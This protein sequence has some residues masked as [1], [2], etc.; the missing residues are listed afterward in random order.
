MRRRETGLI[1]NNMDKIKTSPLALHELV[2]LYLSGTLLF[3]YLL[4]CVYVF[5]V[6]EGCVEV[7]RLF[8][9][10]SS[11]FPPSESYKWNSDCQVWQ[12]SPLPAEPSPWPLKKKNL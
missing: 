12:D 1:Q 2:W 6:W 7:R 11:G 9:G 8:A 4:K 10:V 3:I 5:V